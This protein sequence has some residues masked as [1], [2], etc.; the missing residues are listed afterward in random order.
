MELYGTA[1]SLDFEETQLCWGE[2]AESDE[3]NELYL[4]TCFGMLTKQSNFSRLPHTGS[5][6]FVNDMDG[7]GDKDLLLGDV[8]YPDLFL[9]NNDGSSEYAHMSSF[10]NIFPQNSR[11]L[12]LFSMPQASYIDV[13]NDGVRDLIVSPFDPSPYTSENFKSIWYY[14]N[15]GLDNI[16]EFSFC[17]G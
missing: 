5:T 1:D 14:K 16:P 13:D 9:L 15:T 17:S 10:T 7:D 11:V 8:D 4:D 2:F 6:F 3:S 12:K